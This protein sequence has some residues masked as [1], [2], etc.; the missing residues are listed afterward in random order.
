MT[1]SDGV[2]LDD[3]NAYSRRFATRLFQRHPDWRPLATTPPW[4]DADPDALYVAIV[5]P[6]GSDRWLEVTTN[7]GQVEVTVHF[8]G[9]GFEGIF[10]EARTAS[11]E[12]LVFTSALEMIEGVLTENLVFM[13][14]FAGGE[15]IWADLARTTGGCP[16]DGADR[17]ELSS[18]MRTKDAVWTRA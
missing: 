1:R 13:E 7:E 17:I 12:S 8:G 11:D 2:P 14:S 3:L 18:W 16:L 15:S 6:G 10:N 9:V 5:S 4:P